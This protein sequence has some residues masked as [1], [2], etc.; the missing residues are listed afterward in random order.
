MLFAIIYLVSVGDMGKLATVMNSKNAKQPQTEVGAR[1]DCHRLPC[2]LGVAL[3]TCSLT[4]CLPEAIY[5]F[6][7]VQESMCKQHECD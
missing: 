4:F 1:G 5:I 7:C 6:N 3:I 2:A